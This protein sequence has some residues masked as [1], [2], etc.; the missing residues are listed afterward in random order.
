SA[1]EWIARYVK[2]VGLAAANQKIDYMLVT[3]FHDDH[4]G[5]VEY[6]EAKSQ[7]GDY[8]LSGVT[9]VGDHIALGKIIDRGWPDY[10]Y[11][12]PKSTEPDV[13]NYIRFV[14]SQQDRG[15][16]VEQFVVGSKEQFKLLRHAE[17]YP[18]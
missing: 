12:Y 15:V 7:N 18:N 3:H 2:H 8:I 13:A 4:M 16:P 1:G 9:D 14:Q 5:S 17:R 6:S 10:D 11:P